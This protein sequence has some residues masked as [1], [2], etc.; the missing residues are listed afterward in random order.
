MRIDGTLG[1]EGYRTLWRATVIILGVALEQTQVRDDGIIEPVDFAEFVASA[2][3]AVASNA[4]GVGRLTAGRP[5]SRE[6]SLVSQLVRSSAG[7]DPAALARDCAS[8]VGVR[9]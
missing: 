9:P 6:S 7:D 5:G 8:V 4:G 2:L 1:T 3:T